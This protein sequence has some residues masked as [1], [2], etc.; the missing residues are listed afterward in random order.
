MVRI[1][2]DLDQFLGPINLTG[3]DQ[4]ATLSTDQFADPMDKARQ[5]IIGEASR[6]TTDELPVSSPLRNSFRN[7]DWTFHVWA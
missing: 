6:T 4:D 2:E 1:P 5:P 7:C 3:H